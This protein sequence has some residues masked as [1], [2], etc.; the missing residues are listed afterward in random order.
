MSP[1]G[2]GMRLEWFLARRYLAS[3]R[4]GRFLSFI[5]G[6]ALGGVVVG[7]SALVVVLGV[8]NGMQTELRERIVGSTAHLLVLQRGAALRLDDWRG[9]RDRVVGVPGVVAAAPFV[10]TEVTLI[11]EGYA[12]PAQLFGVPVGEGQ[13]PVTDLEEEILAGL[14]SLEPTPSGSRPVLV[15]SRLAGRMTLFPGDTVVLG[16]IENLRRDPLGGLNIPFRPFE[17]TGTVSTGMYDYDLRNLYVRLEDAQEILGI[18][19]LDQVS[20]IA[21]RIRDPWEAA[22]AAE[23][24]EEG[25]GPAFAVESWIAQNQALFSALELEKLAMG[26]IL[27]LIVLVAS[28]NIVSTLVMV[29]VD[30]TREIGILK[31]MGMTDGGILRVFVLQGVWIGAIGSAAGLVLGLASGWAIDR[32]RLIEIPANVYFVDRLPVRF[33]P[34]ELVLIF[35]VSVA[36]SFVATLYPARTAARLRPVEAI[37][38]E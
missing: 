27:F 22:S 15:G 6:V 37:R 33:D 30:R 35:G 32:F 34:I 26:L 38:H 20:G 36:V 11:R 18:R 21:V 17:V 29:V 2:G 3:R 24:L 5:T 9:I 28:F 7:V 8:M 13:V 23:A 25:L 14:H 1:A 19:D 12:Q 31:S 10:L 16:G 4:R